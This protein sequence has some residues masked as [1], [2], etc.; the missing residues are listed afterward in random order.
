MGLIS[1]FKIIIFIGV[2]IGISLGLESFYPGLVN[3]GGFVSLITL[4]VG[5][6]AIYLYLKQKEDYRRD[7]SNIL[8]MEIR[9][10]EQMIEK[11]RN[12]GVPIIISIE[13]LL[14]TN[15]WNKYNHLFIKILDRDE[16]DAINNFYNQCTLIDKAL[17]QLNLPLQLEQKSQSIH[18]TLS[19]IA[20]DSISEPDFQNKRDSYIKLI[21]PDEYLFKPKALME[22]IG[23]A[24]TTVQFIIT[25]T[26]G[27]KLKK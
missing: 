27:S 12:S 25:T 20:K 17:S 8:L 4:L 7:A 15:N 19:L 23:R 21:N 5:S 13:L 16:I 10:A 2:V 11:Y 26:T 22:A 9:H 18:Q 24:L 14:P 1:E 6:F 3:S